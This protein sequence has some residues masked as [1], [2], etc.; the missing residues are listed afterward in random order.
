MLM[1]LSYLVVCALWITPLVQGCKHVILI[2][3]VTLTIGTNKRMRSIYENS[4]CAK[5]MKFRW[6]INHSGLWKTVCFAECQQDDGSA[7]VIL[8]L[9]FCFGQ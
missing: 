9:F 8:K 5:N 1:L 4:T 3:T 6:E 7:S 2:T